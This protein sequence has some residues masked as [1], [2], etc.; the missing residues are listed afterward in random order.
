MF[1][2]VLTHIKQNICGHQMDLVIRICAPLEEFSMKRKWQIQASSQAFLLLNISTESNIL[3]EKKKGEGIEVNM[4]KIGI[5]GSCGGEKQWLY[6]PPR[7]IHHQTPLNSI[8]QQ[9]PP[10][11]WTSKTCENQMWSSSWQHKNMPECR[12][13]SSC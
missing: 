8:H 9:T 5:Y 2:L 3:T 4:R 12:H 1:F 7:F 13:C 11:G 6:E 10:K